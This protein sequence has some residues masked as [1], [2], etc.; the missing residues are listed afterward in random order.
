MSKTATA[1]LTPS[2]TEVFGPS[3]NQKTIGVLHVCQFSSNPDA[4]RTATANLAATRSTYIS[5]GNSSDGNKGGANLILGSANSKTVTDNAATYVAALEGAMDVPM[6]T[7][8]A[9]A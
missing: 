3:T 2:A 6:N 1:S 4:A 5:V 9:T 7:V 8:V